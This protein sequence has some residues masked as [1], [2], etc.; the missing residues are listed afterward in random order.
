MS[1]PRFQPG[2]RWEHE[3][4]AE[5]WG[6]RVIDAVQAVLAEDNTGVEVES[7]RADDG[8]LIVVYR[9]PATAGRLGHRRSLIA[10]PP[11]GDPSGDLAE[12]LGAWIANF[13]LIEPTPRLQPP[14]QDGIRWSR[15]PITRH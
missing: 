12:W 15:H 11:V 9:H 10:P 4:S 8:Q 5:D 3:T 6:G 7:I 1:D 14:D 13:E 2:D